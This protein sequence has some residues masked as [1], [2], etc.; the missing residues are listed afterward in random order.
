MLLILNFILFS[1]QVTNVII[2]FLLFLFSPIFRTLT[3]TYSEDTI[4]LLSL[5]LIGIHLFTPPPPTEHQHRVDI[6]PILFVSILFASRLKTS[7]HS[8]GI[9]L[10]CFLLFLNVKPY[11]KEW[12]ISL[13][14]FTFGLIYFHSVLWSFLYL[15]KILILSFLVPLALIYVQ[16]F[17]DEIEGP[18]DVKS[19][20]GV[21]E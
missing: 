12:R 19:P 4:H 6:K 21:T 10:F 16:Q 1:P 8:F 15:F 13:Y 9:I 14:F 20:I 18:W 11:L 3:V 17:K 2:L 5:L 7:F